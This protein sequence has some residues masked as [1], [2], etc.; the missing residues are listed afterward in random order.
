MKQFRIF[1]LVLIGLFSIT[2]FAQKKAKTHKIVFQFTNANDSLQS[3]AFVKQLENLTDYWPKATYEVV[4]YNQGLELVMKKNPKFYS[5]LKNLKE[6]RGVKFVVCENTLKNRKIE[7]STL[8]E[9]LLEY[10]PA[11]IAEIV[12]KQEAGWNYIKG[13][14]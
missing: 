7:K 14:F 8:L 11:G 5:K 3:K 12:E 10:V 1:V 2:S 6:N 4:L 13:G 9:D